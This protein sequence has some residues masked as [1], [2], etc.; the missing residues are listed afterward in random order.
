[1]SFK[2][3]TGNVAVPSA[4]TTVTASDGDSCTIKITASCY[5]TDGWVQSTGVVAKFYV[6]GVLKST[7]TL[8]GNG[9]SYSASAKKTKT[10]SY[11]V[12]RSHSSKTSAWK[13]Q[14]HQYTDG[15]DQG[16]KVYIN[17]SRTIAAQTSYT[18][19]YNANDGTGAPANQTKW[20][21]DALT[22]SSTKPTRTGYT[23]SKWNTNSGGTGTAYSA[24]GSYTANAAATLY[25][26][27]TANTYTI[28][29]KANGGTCSTAS[30]SKTY[31][32]TI[33]LPTPTRTNYKFLGWATS[34][35]ATSGLAAGSSYTVTGNTTLYALWELS[36]YKPRANNFKVIRCNSAGTA[37]DYGTYLKVTFNIDVCTLTSSTNVL[38]T[39]AFEWTGDSTN[40]ASFTESRATGA[41]SKV[42]GG[43]ISSETSYTLKTILTDN[44]GGTDTVTKTVGVAKWPID[45]YGGKD[46]LGNEASGV[47][48]GK[49]SELADYFDV[50]Y[51]S[52]FRMPVEFDNTKGIMGID[53]T[54]VPRHNFQPNN[55]YN[56]V[57]VGYGNYSANIGST[58]IY[59]YDINI[60]SKGGI[61]TNVPVMSHA[62]TVNCSTALTL[63]NALQT[64]KMGN[65]YQQS[66]ETGL[67]TVSNG[68]VVC[69]RTGK[70]LAFASVYATGMAVGDTLQVGIYRNGNVVGY[71]AYV[72]SG[73]AKYSLAHTAPKVMPVS[74]GAVISLQAR[75][76]TQK[77]GSIAANAGTMLTIM[78]LE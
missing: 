21:G 12:N 13:V 38:K 40:D 42:I 35:T 11:T 56:S 63:T 75:N 9:T 26:Q 34:S 46:S 4:S 73:A 6:D 41:F 54:G 14:F 24:G 43:S 33:T 52:R 1:M 67:F 37:D 59:G 55:L 65:L 45:L 19:K 57:L 70:V 17:G 36:Y 16:M 50:A 53:T 25:A 72:N 66:G 64:V 18:I 69:N 31:N 74:A 78:Y 8:L 27:W 68:T 61:T 71:S 49:V 5:L 3:S 77:G 7:Q 47:S 15:T 58:D 2:L 20:Y 76:Y 44:L 39:V 51:T 29:F 48:I 62:I 60:L 28:T 22:L 32:G 10:Y 30:L 23:F